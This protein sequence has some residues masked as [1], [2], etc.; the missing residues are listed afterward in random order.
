MATGEEIPC[1]VD[2]LSAKVHD[3]LKHELLSRS[4]FVAAKP[5]ADVLT[6]IITELSPCDTRQFSKQT[7]VL[8]E[9]ETYAKAA[10]ED[11][12]HRTP[13]L[14]AP[15]SCVMICDPGNRGVDCEC[16]LVLLRGLR[17]AG[18]IQPLGVIANLRPSGDCAR[19]LR[20]TL[21]LLGV[22]HVP[23]GIGSND[24]VHSGPTD[25]ADSSWTNA[26][27]YIT[28][29]NSGRNGGNHYWSTATT[30]GV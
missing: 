2:Q 26:Q 7:Q 12:L 15:T 1:A 17:D 6:K 13:K 11:G 3:P 21:D 25:H 16:A 10:W 30:E 5:S 29:P 28:P 19:L 23:V 27:S 22:H 20:V 8:V 18:Y 9:V 4:L 24:G 14:R